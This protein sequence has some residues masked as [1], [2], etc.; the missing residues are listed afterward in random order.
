LKLSANIQ[1]ATEKHPVKLIAIF[2]A[3]AWNFDAK[4]H[5]HF[6]PVPTCMNRPS[7]IWYSL[8]VAKLQNFRSY[9]L[10]VS[11]RNLNPSLN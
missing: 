8:T 11:H 1:G 4:F 10:T 5:T 7:G 6:L 9:L 3:T 2:S